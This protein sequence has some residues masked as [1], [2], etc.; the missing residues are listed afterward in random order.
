LGHSPLAAA[1]VSATIRAG[2]MRRAS[3]LSPLTDSDSPRPLSALSASAHEIPL[4]IRSLA[5][6]LDAHRK[7]QQGLVSV[8]K[9]IHDQLDLAVFAAY[10]WPP[11]L[12][13]EQI[14]ERLAAVGVAVEVTAPQA[15]ERRWRAT[16]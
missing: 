12:F 13:D 3:T 2:E 10:G 7:R 16:R 15:A 14:L 1:S 6:S 8:L 4:R 9:Q 5:E 11:T